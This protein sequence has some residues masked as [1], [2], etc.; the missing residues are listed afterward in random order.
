MYH[1]APPPKPVLEPQKVGFILSVPVSF[2]RKMTGHGQG[3]GGGKPYHKWGVWGGVLWYVFPSPEYS[4]PLC[5][6]LTRW[7]PKRV[8]LV[9]VPG[10][11]TPEQ[12]TKTER[13]YQKSERGNKNGTT[14]PRTG[15]RA[16]LLQSPPFSEKNLVSVKFVSAIL[17]PD[18][19]APILWAPGKMRPF[20]REK[21]C[22]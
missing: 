12:G 14:V 16:H 21:P 6:S 10:P 18:M 4:T 20:C 13:Q 22:P 15:T 9:D 5:R 11:Q 7:F 2:L 17:G 19:A 8:V 1:R 3:G